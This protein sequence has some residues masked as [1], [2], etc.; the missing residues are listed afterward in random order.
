MFP[1]LCFLLW[2]SFQNPHLCT[3]F[4]DLCH[5]PYHSLLFV[6]TLVFLN[7][8]RAFV[9]LQLHGMI[10]RTVLALPSLFLFFAKVPMLRAFFMPHLTPHFIPPMSVF[11]KWRKYSAQKKARET[12]QPELSTHSELK[13]SQNSVPILYRDLLPVSCPSRLK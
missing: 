4:H 8:G 9:T 11:I 13:C 2:C 12:L 6:L 7:R 1:F 10:Q 3:V 5:V